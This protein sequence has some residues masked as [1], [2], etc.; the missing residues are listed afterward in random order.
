MKKILA[1]LYLLGF[2]TCDVAGQSYKFLYYLD[3]DLISTEKEKASFIGKGLRDSTSFLVDCFDIKTGKLSMSVHF[4]DSLLSNFEGLYKEY[5]LSGL[6]KD[7]GNYLNGNQQGEW[8]LWDS[9]GLKTLSI[10]FENGKQISLTEYNYYKGRLSNKSLKDSLGVEK[11]LVLFDEKGKEVKEGEIFKRVDIRPIFPGK[12]TFQE[13]LLQ[14]SDRN[15]PALRG[16]PSGR[17]LVVI[18][19]VVDASECSWT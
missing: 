6:L 19:F 10:L 12:L 4:N 11:S 2:L 5:H 9:T 16:A 7:E 1:A 18:N 8:S 15:I 13:Y 3:K 17:Y 14:N